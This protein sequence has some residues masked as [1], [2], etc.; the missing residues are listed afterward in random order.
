MR[1]Y[2]TTRSAWTLGGLVLVGTLAGFVMGRKSLPFNRIQRV[3]VPVVASS[4]FRP[5]E[6]TINVRQEETDQS[7]AL[8]EAALGARTKVRINLNAFHAAQLAYR[9]VYGRFT[10]DM[11]A[12][13]W[14]PI[15]SQL[16]YKLGFLS[17]SQMAA[18]GE[19][20]T[21][22]DTDVYLAEVDPDSDV[23]FTYTPRATLINLNLYTALC[24][25]GC[26]ASAQGYELMLAIPLDEEGRVDVWL[27]NEQKQLVQVWD[28]MTGQRLQ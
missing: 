23:P 14:T 8:D 21:Q 3:E 26:S 1:R 28:G 27:L 10:T 22:R 6:V 17:S 25:K 16:D 5:Q 19:D 2:M 12:L 9:D 7:P 11:L 24:R 15:G 20:P 4:S 13:E 18:D